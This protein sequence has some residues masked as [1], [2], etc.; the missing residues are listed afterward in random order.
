M[1]I[2]AFIQ[3]FHFKH[4]NKELWFICQFKLCM[5]GPEAVKRNAA[6]ILLK[7]ILAAVTRI[8]YIL[9]PSAFVANRKQN[10]QTLFAKQNRRSE[11]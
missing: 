5:E 6:L 10:N 1:F 3:V 2:L 4:L 7:N 8:F 11:L 9:S